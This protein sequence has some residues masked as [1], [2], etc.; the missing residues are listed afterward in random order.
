MGLTG[1]GRRIFLGFWLFPSE[2]AFVWE[3]LL[4]ELRSRGP[5]E[6]LLFITDG[7]D[8]VEEAI[9]RVYSQAE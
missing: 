6:V 5:V 1:D 7:P 4:K 8:G 2:G 9:R 3:E